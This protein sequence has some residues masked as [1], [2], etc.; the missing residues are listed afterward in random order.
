MSTEIKNSRWLLIDV[1]KEATRFLESHGITYARGNAEQ[2]LS[3]V[4]ESDRIGLYLNFEQPL[5]EN[6]RK[7]YKQLLRRR[8]QREPLQYLIGR[9]E[10]MSLPFRVKPGVLIPRPETEI[11][12]E[13]TIEQIKERFDPDKTVMCL[14]IGTGSGNIAVSLAYELRNVHVVAVDRDKDTLAVA[15]ENADVNGVGNRIKFMFLNIVDENSIEKIS[16]RF[17]IVVSNPPYVSAEAYEQLPDEIREHEPKIALDG[18]RDGLRFYRRLARILP[19][20]LEKNGLALFEIGPD[21]AGSVITIF[22]KSFPNPIEII[23]DLAGR[24]RVVCLQ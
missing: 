21:Q 15:K 2:L 8:T 14:D 12:V 7:V 19:E 18:G 9:T 3:Y 16:Q 6:E 11:L 4:L 13:K 17:D 20:L 10:F 1:L 24:D 5:S 22:E 23:K